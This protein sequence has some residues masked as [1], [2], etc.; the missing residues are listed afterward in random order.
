MQQL[1]TLPNQ[2][3]FSG[4]RDF[5]LIMLTLDTGIRPKE[6][7]SL[8]ESDIN[9]KN[10]SVE[11]RAQ[12]AKTRVSRSLPI[13]PATAQVIKKLLSARHP[14]WNNNVPV[15][16]TADGTFLNACTWG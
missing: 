2:K 3:T 16:S 6:A 13:L 12:I 15:F 4:L 7:F 1:L 5:A 10:Y 9:L 8:L 11:V 14:D